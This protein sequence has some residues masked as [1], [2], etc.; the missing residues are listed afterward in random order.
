MLRPGHN[1]VCYPDPMNDLTFASLLFLPRRK[2]RVWEI[3]TENSCTAP[4]YK[5]SDIRASSASYW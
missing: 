5:Q 1:S 2:S 4:Q 3:L